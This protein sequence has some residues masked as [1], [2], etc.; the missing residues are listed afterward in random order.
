MPDVEVPEQFHHFMLNKPHGCITAKE[1]WEDRELVYDHIPDKFPHVGH[2]GRLDYNTQGLLLFTD[3]GRL[4]QALLNKEYAG[5]ADPETTEPIEKVYHV[6]IKDVIEPDDPLFEELEEPLEFEPGRFTEPAT[7]EY[8]APRSSCTWIAITICEGRHRQVRKLC[9]RSGR[10]IRK[11]RRVKL[12]PLELGDLKM[13][14]CRWLTDDEIRSLYEVALP[15][16]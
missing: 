4:S 13:R 3:D 7:A 16:G 8:V 12:G 6:K 2:V 5:E 1:D 15:E 14:W 9:K 11:L 10:Q